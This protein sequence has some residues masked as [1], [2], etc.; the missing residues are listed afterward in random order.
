M[1]EF[2]LTSL[3]SENEQ[4]FEELHDDF[5]KK[6]LPVFY[7]KIKDYLKVTSSPTEKH[8]ADLEGNSSNVERFSKLKKWLDNEGVRARSHFVKKI[9]LFRNTMI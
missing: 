1:K 9:E 8:I 7:E 4:R 3:L 5:L 2:A 6:I